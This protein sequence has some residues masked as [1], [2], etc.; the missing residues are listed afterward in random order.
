MALLSKAQ[1]S[2]TGGFICFSGWAGSVLVGSLPSLAGLLGDTG[3]GAQEPGWGWC[4]PS[5]RWG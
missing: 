2:G 5:P 3:A 4:G 1:A